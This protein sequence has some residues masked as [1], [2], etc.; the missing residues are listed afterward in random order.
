M[1][2]EEFGQ[3]RGPRLAGGQIVAPWAQRLCHEVCQRRRPGVAH[4]GRYFYGRTELGDLAVERPLTERIGQLRSRPVQSFRRLLAAVIG[5]LRVVAR[6]CGRRASRLGQGRRVLSLGEGAPDLTDVLAPAG[7]QVSHKSRQVGPSELVPVKRPGHSGQVGGLGHGGEGTVG[8]GRDLPQYVI[9]P[10]SSGDGLV[11]VDLRLRQTMLGLF[12]LGDV[13]D[14]PFF[15]FSQAFG[16]AVGGR[17][18]HGPLSLLGDLPVLVAGQL[19]LAQPLGL[20]RGGDHFLFGFA[21][22]APRCS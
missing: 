5:L 1:L 20:V 2:V 13:I 8:F 14:Q 17:D 10:L 18:E 3:V 15:D 6:Q 7:A 22:P 9:G 19:G 11:A 16:I 21:H 12:Q 4:G